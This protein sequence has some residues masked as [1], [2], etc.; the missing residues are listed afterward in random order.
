M[1]GKPKSGGQDSIADKLPDGW[2]CDACSDTL[3]DIVYSL[4]T[5]IARI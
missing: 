3:I 2:A 4:R 1:H 5:Q